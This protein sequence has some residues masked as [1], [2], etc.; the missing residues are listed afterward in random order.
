MV[1]LNQLGNIQ[2]NQS[3]PSGSIAHLQSGARLMCSIPEFK[4]VP[5]QHFTEAC[6][7]ASVQG[8][9]ASPRLARA[10]KRALER[11][12]KSM[13]LKTLTLLFT[14][15]FIFYSMNDVFINL[16]I[17]LFNGSKIP[18]IFTYRIFLFINY[19]LC[20]S[21]SITKITSHVFSDSVT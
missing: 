13:S 21:F 18:E 15:T 7:S 16:S 8:A 5:R 2:S 3:W 4:Q 6:R 19:I 9:C 1:Q 14:L 17:L 11:L 10:P 12:L 20:S